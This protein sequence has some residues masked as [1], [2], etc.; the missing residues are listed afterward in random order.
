MKS[1]QEN[2]KHRNPHIMKKNW[3]RQVNSQQKGQFLGDLFEI[4][5]QYR[6][7][8]HRSHANCFT[9][10]KGPE[11]KQQC[12]KKNRSKQICFNAWLTRANVIWRRKLKF[13]TELKGDLLYSSSGWIHPRSQIDWFVLDRSLLKSQPTAKFQLQELG[14]NKRPWA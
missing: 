7:D 5:Y 1:N 4:F 6:R 13:L 11:K 3:R 14:S 10:V 8:K 12:K 2:A 9:V